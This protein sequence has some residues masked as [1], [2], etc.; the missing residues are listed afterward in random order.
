MHLSSRPK[1]LRSAHF[2]EKHPP[3]AVSYGALDALYE[4][5]TRLAETRLA[6]NTLT[7]MIYAITSK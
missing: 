2:L 3:R 1:L 7:Y 6:Q 5:I 4:E